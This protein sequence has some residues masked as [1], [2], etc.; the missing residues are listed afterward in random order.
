MLARS[1]RLDTSHLMPRT[2][3]GK[4]TLLLAVL[5][6]AGCGGSSEPNAHPQVVRGRGFSFEAPAGWRVQHSVQGSAAARGSELVQVSTFPLAR[7]YT[8]A[9]FG[10]V[11]REL[12]LRMQTI[13]HETNGTLTGMNTVTAGG[14]KSHRFDVKVDDHVDQ[15]TFVLIG[16][17]EYQLLCRVQTSSSDAF[18]SDLLTSFRP[19]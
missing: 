1:F 4:Q 12:R 16:K 2:L 7:P 17:R 13:A 11:A 6:L 5:I 9:L 15:Y 18:C 3:R 14:V 10:R 8:P 19:A